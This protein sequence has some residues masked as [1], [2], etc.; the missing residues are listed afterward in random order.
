[1]IK[2]IRIT[3]ERK[4]KLSK[5]KIIALILIIFFSIVTITGCNIV[6]GEN[7]QEEENNQESETEKD[8]SLEEKDPNE[9][10]ENVEEIEEI[11][12]LTE[13]TITA[14]GDVMVHESQLNAQY[15]ETEDSYDF[16][17]NF[18]YLEPYLENSDIN[19]ANLETTFAGR[20]RGYSSF[21]L[22]NTPDALGKALGEAGFN[23]IST[24]N[25]HTF[26][27]GEQGF[28]RTLEVLEEQGLIPVGTRMDE[29]EDR[30]VIE[31]IENIKVGI[32]AYTYET[33]R[34]E[35]QITLNGISI[36]SH[37]E[38]LMN[39]F[40]DHYKEEA[41][42]EMEEIIQGMK[43]DGAEVIIFNL[44][45]GNEYHREP[46]DHQR[47]L[48]TKLSEL[49]VDII[50]GSHPHVVQPIDII[51]NNGQE[52]LVIYS[53]G[54]LISNQREETLRNY[55]NNAQY[56]EDGLMVHVTFQKSSLSGEIE[57]TLVEYTPLW[58]HRYTRGNGFGY[59][60]LPV[61]EAIENFDAFNIQSDA[62]KN[63]LRTSLERTEAMVNMNI[64]SFIL[65]THTSE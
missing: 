46:S 41:L 55:T 37:L 31:E 4:I 43:A 3:N 56:T 33:Q 6:E 53:M 61:A 63:R 49:G 22:F 38:P 21:P 36:P 57:R 27:T 7:N 47:E 25:N 26:D 42:V 65:K 17:N 60:V 32:T 1:M 59:S 40:H 64:D 12:E 5:A 11:E 13:V 54:N 10:Q 18:E 16:S 15:D 19:I 8:N 24:I 9:E 52:T 44:H 34:N 50:F 30:Y 45:W 14:V 35:E 39:T 20:D 58:V 51:E 28:F 62:L 48:A 23:I 29:T 2:Y